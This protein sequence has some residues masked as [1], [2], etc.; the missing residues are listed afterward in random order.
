MVEFEFSEDDFQSKAAFNQS[1]SGGRLHTHNRIVN[2]NNPIFSKMSQQ[3]AD[4][5]SI[6]PENC[7]SI[8][9][10]GTTA[11]RSERLLMTQAERIEFYNFLDGVLGPAHGVQESVGTYKTYMENQ[12]RLCFERTLKNGISAKQQ[13]NGESIEESG[14]LHSASQASAFS[15]ISCDS[16]VNWRN[17]LGPGSNQDMHALAKPASY[18]HSDS[19]GA[20]HTRTL[21]GRATP[22]ILS[23]SVPA[24]EETF[25][26]HLSDLEVSNSIGDQ[27][28]ESLLLVNASRCIAPSKGRTEEHPSRS[29]PQLLLPDL[30]RSQSDSPDLESSP[31]IQTPTPIYQQFS[32]PKDFHFGLLHPVLRRAHWTPTIQSEDNLSNARP[33]HAYGS[34]DRK[35]SSQQSDIHTTVLPVREYSISTLASRIRMRS[36]SSGSNSV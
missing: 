7:S 36:K 9:S 6:F 34:S 27:A 8:V 1:H 16:S 20:Y 33:S 13:V 2:P 28:L 21:Q 18:Y 15:S 35:Q 17:W 10:S 12:A 5:T 4:T 26:D 29:S 14:T 19:D 30:H 31:F 3:H 24:S 23:Q 32:Q 11:T 25:E 22:S